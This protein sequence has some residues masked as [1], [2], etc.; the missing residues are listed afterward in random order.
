MCG[1]GGDGGRR[2]CVYFVSGVPTALGRVPG[3]LGEVNDHWLIIGKLTSLHLKLVIRSL[4][5]S[6]P[7]V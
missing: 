1:G 3:S 2:G 4:G 5:L 7:N 6:K